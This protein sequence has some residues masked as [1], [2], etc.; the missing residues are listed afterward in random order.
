EAE[1]IEVQAGGVVRWCFAAERAREQDVEAPARVARAPEHGVER[2]P[3][4]G[5]GLPEPMDVV[6]GEHE[7]TSAGPGALEGALEEGGPRGRGFVGGCARRCCARPL[8]GGGVLER[9]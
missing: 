2:L 8:P 6:E 5:A 7:G 9:L 4:A 1:G 3:P